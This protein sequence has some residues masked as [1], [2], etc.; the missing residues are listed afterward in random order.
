[1]TVDRLTHKGVA[2]HRAT[3]PGCKPGGAWFARPVGTA[4][5]LCAPD[6]AGIIAAIDAHIGRA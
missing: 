2:A 4:A 1:M 5:P 6:R 3:W